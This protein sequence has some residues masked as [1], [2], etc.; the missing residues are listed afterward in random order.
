MN[1]RY[2]PLL[3]TTVIG[4]HPQPDWLID[5]EALAHRSPPR[6]RAREIWRIEPAHLAEAQNDATRV[7]IRDLEEA[8][9]D[10]I[11]D[12]EMRRESYSN[13]FSNALEG[14]DP[15][16]PGAGL[17]RTGRPDV[18]PLVNGPIRRKGPVE[19]DA[20]GF[21]VAHTDRA[22]KVTVPGPF[23]MSQQ[24]QN[25]HYDSRRE[26][27]LA[28]ADALN[29]EIRDLF[30]AGVDVVQ[31][32]EPYLQSFTEDARQY[33][34]EAINRS[35]TGVVG[36]TVLHTCF[37]YG[38]FI[39]EKTSGYPFLEE[40]GDTVASQLAI[41]AAQ[42]NLDLSVLDSFDRHTIVLGVID[43]ADPE[44][45]LPEVVA[46]R[47]EAALEHVPVERLV[48]A[49]DCGMKYLPR[50]LAQQKLA[51]LVAGAAMVRGRLGLGTAG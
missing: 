46:G 4:S 26:L 49:P 18:V 19:V 33:A 40:L 51:S 1:S 14:V 30:D 21:L 29:A 13:H 41:E 16:T 37:G 11:T 43:L 9:I 8:G 23:T 39:A 45:E 42:P 44:P 48:L 36:T 6:V 38:H 17:T 10:I 7:A 2:L 32:D 24:A 50:P 5:R 34:V 25:D 20:V 35:L 28:L 47:I 31:I 3:P 15:N 22:T 27:A 12:G